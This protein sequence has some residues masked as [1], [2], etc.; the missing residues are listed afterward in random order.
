MDNPK[1]AWI[2][3]TIIVVSARRGC[4]LKEITEI[5]LKFKNPTVA[6]DSNNKNVSMPPYITKGL[7]RNIV[8][9][10]L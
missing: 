6:V 5:P 8:S 2:T 3:A 4:H 1:T 10:M 7:P 9:A